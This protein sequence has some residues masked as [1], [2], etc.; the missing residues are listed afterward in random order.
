MIRA[1]SCEVQISATFSLN[2][3][4]TARNVYRGRQ[5]VDTAPELNG[6]ASCWPVSE[7][8]ANCC[9]NN[10]GCITGSSTYGSARSINC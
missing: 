7:A 6:S 9:V 2:G 1:V 10:F 4:S 5:I 3:D 8:P